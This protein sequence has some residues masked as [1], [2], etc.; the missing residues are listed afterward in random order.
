MTPDRYDDYRAALA[1]VTLPAA[2]VDLDL[3]ETNAAT[4]R[5]RADG[6]PVRVASKSVRCRAVLDRVLAFDD[7]FQGLMCFSGLEAG[8]LDRK[9]VV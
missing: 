3:L 7:C 2:F 4:V 5:D 8:H 1:D 9:S 6:T